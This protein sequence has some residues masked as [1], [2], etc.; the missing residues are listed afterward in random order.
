MVDRQQILVEEVDLWQIA[1]QDAATIFQEK[2][3]IGVYAH[4][5]LQ[6]GQRD[7][8]QHRENYCRGDDFG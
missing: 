5:R 1:S 8:Q 4:W 6:N 2:G 7:S 3:D